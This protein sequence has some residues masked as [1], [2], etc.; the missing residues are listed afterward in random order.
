MAH[1][2]R[3]QVPRWASSRFQQ[4]FIIWPVFFFVHCNSVRTTLLPADKLAQ[5]G[6]S[7]ER[8]AC[9][10]ASRRPLFPRFRHTYP[11]QMGAII[12]RFLFFTSA[13]RKPYC[14]DLRP[15]RPMKICW[16]FALTTSN[17]SKVQGEERSH[18][19]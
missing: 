14:L 19:E 11:L 3:V 10:M 4:R 1:Y 13:M 5:R 16:H 18:L 17:K 9:T 12:S 2:D 8:P 7:A 6:K 15:V